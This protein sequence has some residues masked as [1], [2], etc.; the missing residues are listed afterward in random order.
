MLYESSAEMVEY[1]QQALKQAALEATVLLYSPGIDPFLEDLTK[2]ADRVSYFEKG[3]RK[4]PK[5]TA[6]TWLKMEDQK[7]LE[8]FS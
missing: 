7:T 3:L 5:L 6:K 1:I 8:A 4:T 2:G